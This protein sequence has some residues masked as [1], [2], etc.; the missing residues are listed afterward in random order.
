M[1]N[2]ATA[3]K[4]SPSDVFWD[5]CVPALG[6]Q[7]QQVMFD[8]FGKCASEMQSTLYTFHISK[9][10]PEIPKCDVGLYLVP[11]RRGVR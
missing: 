3:M 8:R 4:K 7:Y 1:A 6:M 2:V 5:P 9:Y 11:R 10:A